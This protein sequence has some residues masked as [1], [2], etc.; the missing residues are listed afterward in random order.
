MALYLTTAMTDLMFCNAT[1][2]K[3]EEIAPETL[4]SMINDLTICYSNE[5]MIINAMNTRFG[6]NVFKFSPVV[7]VLK[8]GD[9]IIILSCTNLPK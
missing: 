3:R 1:Y 9:R 5:K 6:T 8:S 7:P 2:I 4:M